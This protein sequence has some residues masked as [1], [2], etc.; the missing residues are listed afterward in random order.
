MAPEQATGCATPASDWYAFGVMLFEALAGQVPFADRGELVLLRKQQQDAP[1]LSSI[2]QGISEDLQHL[3]AKLLQRDP[4]ARA[5]FRE[6]IRMLGASNLQP[7]IVRETEAALFEVR[8]DELAALNQ[9]LEATEDG[10]PA[11]A[12]VHGAQGAGKSALAEHFAADVCRQGKAVV[13]KGCCNERE[14]LPYNAWDGLIDDLT[15]YLKKLPIHRAAQM[16]PRQIHAL[17]RVFPVLQRL[18]AVRQVKQ[19]RPLPTDAV[20]LRRTAFLALRELLANIAEQ[21]PLVLFIDD[22]QHGDNDSSELLR[23]LLS[24]PDSPPFLFI[25]AYR[26]ERADAN[27]VLKAVREF[28]DKLKAVNVIEIKLNPPKASKASY[29]Q[30]PRRHGSVAA[31]LAA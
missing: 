29:E 27:P 6:V 15:H 3:C 21:E 28:A 4:E 10:R 30:D 20:E 31:Q 7:E 9:A 22:L 11:V 1:L 23:F 18:D 17:A 2:R 16:L 19:R 5:D 14:S 13:L 25:G 24:A 26:S 12:F 8:E